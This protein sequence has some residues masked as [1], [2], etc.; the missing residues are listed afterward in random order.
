MVETRQNMKEKLEWCPFFKF[1]WWQLWKIWAR[2]WLTNFKLPLQVCKA[3]RLVDFCGSEPI[4][5]SIPQTLYSW[6]RRCMVCAIL[7]QLIYYSMWWHVQTFNISVHWCFYRYTVNLVVFF[8]SKK[9]PGQYHDTFGFLTALCSVWVG[10]LTFKL[11]TAEL[12]DRSSGAASLLLPLSTKER[13]IM[14]KEENHKL[15]NGNSVEP[16]DRVWWSFNL[17]KFNI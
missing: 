6:C 9:L 4:N 3:V 5:Y 10:N 14:N 7:I 13:D 17:G 2:T 16:A 12:P 11:S 1:L 15:I 8:I